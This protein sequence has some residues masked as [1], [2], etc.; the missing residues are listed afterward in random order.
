[1]TTVAGSSWKDR[2]YSQCREKALWGSRV[3]WKACVL[4]NQDK[5]L[6]PTA[7]YKLAEQAVFEEDTP[8]IQPSKPW[9][10]L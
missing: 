1:M 2:D 4:M 5:K 10:H 9:W 7:A 3:F 6:K 8:L